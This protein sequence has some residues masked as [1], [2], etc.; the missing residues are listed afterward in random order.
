MTTLSS[1]KGNAHGNVDMFSLG[2][3]AAV[4]AATEQIRDLLLPKHIW[5]VA[6]V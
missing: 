4:N 6:A 1:G 5:H 3:I 2:R